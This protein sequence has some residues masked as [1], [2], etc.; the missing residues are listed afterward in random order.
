VIRQLLIDDGI[1]SERIDVFALGGADD[2][3]PL[4]RV[5]VFLKG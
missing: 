1:P 4:D 2:D 5:D 3:G